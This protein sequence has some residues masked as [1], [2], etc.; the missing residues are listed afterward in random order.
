MQLSKI[1]KICLLSLIVSCSF[2]LINIVYKEYTKQNETK[3]ELTFFFKQYTNDGHKME[4]EYLMVLEIPK[5]NLQKGIYNI[6]DKRNNIDENV[7]I[8]NIEDN[9][10]YL[11]LVSHSGNAFNAYFNDLYKLYFDDSVIIY[12]NKQ[13][14]EYKVK[15]IYRHNKNKNFHL[16]QND[17]NKLILITCLNKEKY[18]IIECIKIK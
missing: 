16:K 3:K 6:S 1:I 2:L 7:T 10:K 11:V 9:L 4:S 14:I 12:Y 18:L 17:E 13:K 5:I 15:R 8:L